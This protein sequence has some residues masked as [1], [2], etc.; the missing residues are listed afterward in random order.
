[1][2]QVNKLYWASF[3]KNQTYFTP[4]LILFLQFH[5]LD[6]KQVFLVFT[7]GSIFNFF[8][9][10]PTGII[11]DLYGKRKSIIISKFII[12]ISFVAF[13]F[14][15]T[16]W[17]FVIAQLLYELGQSFRSGTETAY[18]YDYLKQNPSEP[19]YTEVKGK[20]KFYARIGESIAA[21]IGGFV[22]GH[23]GYNLVFFIAA[24]P[25]FINFLMNLTWAQIQESTEKLNIKSSYL[26][27]IHSFK[28]FK[29]TSLL[30]ITINITIFTSV[31]AALNKF[32]QPYMTDAGVP[33]TMIGFIYAVALGFTAI[34]TRY[35]Y[36][37]EQ[38][39]GEAKTMNWLSTLAIIPAVIIGLGYSSIIGVVLFFL[40]VIA[41]NM[42][43]PIENSIFH[44]NITSKE[45]ATMGSILELVKNLGKTAILPIAGYFAD[46]FS[47][48]TAIL[49]MAGL[50]LINAIFFYI[51][52]TKHGSLKTT[53]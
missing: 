20:Q 22:A 11:A 27:I 8:V 24:I 51:R 14:A 25:A 50:L 37:L 2:K 47:M 42:R 15:S 45:R 17:A 39:F 30:L 34:V 3:L 38:K 16:F 48:A 33:I 49:I 32:V 28:Q 19:S 43:S 21:A 7:I 36:K 12:F 29:N 40:I 31:L 35:S 53:S 41:E 4:I 13:G 23:L 5:H 9:E 1:M 6:F 46:A 44:D 10:I 52:K 18:T 26:H